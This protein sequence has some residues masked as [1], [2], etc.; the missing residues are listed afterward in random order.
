MALFW[1]AS[2]S[3]AGE[4]GAITCVHVRWPRALVAE[5]GE[6]GTTRLGQAQPVKVSA[7][8]DMLVSELRLQVLNALNISARKYVVL[9]RW[10]CELSDEQVLGTFASEGAEIEC[11]TRHMPAGDVDRALH[12]PLRRVRVRAPQ[13]KTTA[14]EVP[15]G[16]SW[17]GLQLKRV[18]VEHKVVDTGNI[19]LFYSRTGLESLGPSTMTKIRDDQQ[20]GT[21]GRQPC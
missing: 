11:S 2:R 3:L 15:E 18:L 1:G 7:N 5:K 12:G 17:T 9:R 16:S 14:L 21:R 20:L 10:G 4:R 6:D 8:E 13:G 19:S